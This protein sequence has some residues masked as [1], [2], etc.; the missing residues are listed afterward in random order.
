MP[1]GLAP[2]LPVN[3]RIARLVA[4]KTGHAL[5]K[6]TIDEE[7]RHRILY[8]SYRQEFYVVKA[9]RVQKMNELKDQKLTDKISH[10]TVKA[11]INISHHQLST[12]EESVLNKG[13]NFAET[14]KWI[15][16]LSII[17]F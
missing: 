8:Q 5:V 10:P 7:D 17:F 4:Q 11:V 12:P 9:G 13:L 14:I 2:S 15:T 3:L 16:Y 1:T 6:R